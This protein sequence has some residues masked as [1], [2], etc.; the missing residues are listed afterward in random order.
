MLSAPCPI[1]DATHGSRPP[2]SAAPRA[3][4]CSITCGILRTSALAECAST[5]TRTSLSAAA[6][7]WM[8]SFQTIRRSAAG[9]PLS[10]ALS[11][12]RER[13]R[14]STSVSCSPTWRRLTFI[15]WRAFSSRLAE[16]TPSCGS[17]RS[18]CW[19]ESRWASSSWR[20]WSRRA[21]SP[22]VLDRPG[23]LT[24]ATPRRAPQD[25]WKCPFKS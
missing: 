3:A 10:G 13:P 11:L 16:P 1:A 14:N 6:S 19:W 20:R 12:R 17:L 23:Q 25:V 9:R 18:G 7:T 22:S 24:S 8:C 15:A 21:E 2:S 4:P 5:R